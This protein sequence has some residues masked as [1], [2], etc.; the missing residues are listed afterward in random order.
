MIE[1]SDTSMIDEVAAAIGEL[2]SLELQIGVQGEEGSFMV[3][4]AT[5]HEFGTEIEVTDKMRGYLGANGMHLKK[6][7]THIVI[8]ERS[9]LRSA[10][11]ENEELFEQVCST[12]VEG[13]FR[14]EMKAVKMLEDIGIIAVDRV[15]KKMRELD[16]PGKHPFTLAKNPGKTNPLIQEGHL[17]ESISSEVKKK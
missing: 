6:T 1:I 9:Y 4:L 12:L 11:D 3:M 15:K 7:T 8:P 14:G 17:L 10:F 2:N 13:M 16:T 5:V